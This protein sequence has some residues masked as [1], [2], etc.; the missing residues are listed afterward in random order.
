MTNFDLP[1][2]G[3][4]Y[5]DDL[6]SWRPL[7]LLVAGEL[8]RPFLPIFR[9]IGRYFKDRA[10]GSPPLSDRMRR[11]IGLPPLG[12]WQGHEPPSNWPGLR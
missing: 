4:T 11:D 10:S 1:R 8:A 5:R 6:N 2:K 9:A 3:N 12:E 7:W